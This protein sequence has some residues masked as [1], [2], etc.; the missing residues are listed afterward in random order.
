MLG[1]IFW[2][3][4]D[5]LRVKEYAIGGRPVPLGGISIAVIG[6]LKAGSGFVDDDKLQDM[7]RKANAARPDLVLL[8]GGY[9][10]SMLPDAVASQLARLE[11]P[12]GVFAVL[13][14]DDTLQMGRAL[15]RSGIFVLRNFHVVIGTRRGPLLLTGLGAG[16]DRALT[17][18][19]PGTTLC[20]AYDAAALDGQACDLAVAG[21]GA[22]AGLA[23]TEGKS[24]FVA[25]G[26]RPDGLWAIPEISLLKIQ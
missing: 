4:P 14:E 20:L 15:E 9:A 6:A 18:R 22:H 16:D 1:A 10:D 11:A 8:T 2:I 21:T 17:P 5:S 3:I 7:V 24:L 13:A 23:Q 25:P 12:M 26:L 19:P